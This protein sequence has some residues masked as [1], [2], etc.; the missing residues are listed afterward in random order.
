MDYKKTI[1]LPQTSFPMKANLAQKE[2]G[3][4]DFWEEKKVY[5]TLQK[6]LKR[7][8]KYILHDGPPYA[9]GHIHLGTAL[10][11]ILKDIVIRYK[12]RKEF[13]APFI[14]GWDCHGMPIEHQLFQELKISQDE[15]NQVDFRKKAAA[16]AL[17]FVEIQKEEFKRLGVAAD[18]ENPYLTLKKEYEAEIINTFGKLAT[19]G[20]IY[21]GFKPIYWCIQCETALAEAEIEYQDDSSPS[22]YVKFPISPESLS[23]LSKLSTFNF[24]L[25][26]FFL[27]W[28]TT[29]WTLPANTAI[30]VHPDLEYALVKVADEVLIL[31][32]IL[33]KEVME[34]VKVSNYEILGKISGKKLEGLKYTHP[35]TP[36]PISSPL[37]GEDKSEGKKKFQIILADFVSSTEGTGCVHSAPGHGEDDYKIGLKYN[38]PILSPVDGKGRFTKEVKEFEGINVF[39]AN[40][41]IIDKMKREGSLFFDEEISHSYP[42]CWRCKKPVIFRATEQW[43]LRVDFS[44]LR[45]RL[46]S[47]VEKVTWVPKEGKERIKSMLENRPDWCLSRQRYWGVPL[48][49]FYCRRCKKPV[50]TEK[51]IENIRKEVEK[52]GSDIWF[53]KEAK[54]ILPENFKCPYC[55]GTEFSKENDIL[56][57][58]FDS[59]VSHRAVLEKNPELGYPADLYLEGSDQHRGWFQTSLLTAVGT[60]NSAPFKTVLTHGFVVDSEGKK[61]SKSLG[62]VITPFEII[63]KDGADILRLWVASEDY[64]ADIRI[65]PEI[66]KHLISAYRSLRNTFRFCLGNLFDFDPEKDQIAASELLEIDSWAIEKAREILNR[67]ENCY[68][69]FDFHNVF[70][71]IYNFCNEALSSFYFDTLKDRLYTYGGKSKERKSAQTAIYQIAVFLLNILAPILSFTAEEVWQNFPRK[72]NEPSSIHL[73]FWPERKEPDKKLLSRWEKFLKLR[74]EI[75]KALEEARIKK[76]IGSSM[77]AKVILAVTDDETINFLKTFPQ[78]TEHLLIAEL[79]TEE[80]KKFEVKVERTQYQK[81]A[82][83][84]IYHQSVGQNREYPDLCEKCISIIATNKHE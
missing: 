76:I 9:N 25:S 58:W 52:E 32:K 66:I 46:V 67:T 77:Q 60:K 54:E 83:C 43:F 30:A 18:W 5:E 14:P 71:T 38:L 79:R 39:S 8:K 41:L 6:N 75:L 2:P 45:K 44:D 34:R 1:L 53:L 23:Q 31:A 74:K 19:A 28:T 72:K 17:K 3:I 47:L 15:V 64:Q 51:T 82:R 37:E 26:T 4:L 65:S 62:N 22:I 61:M 68:E 7:R 48:P 10:N 36:P 42:H 40:K 84:W 56:D 21:Q 11:K 50:L 59:G 20:Y 13:Y 80:K 35:F 70:T 78:I 29:P 57:V 73:L 81:C 63:E 24:Q 49:V 12:S 55:R 69:N 16:F 33:V 27:I